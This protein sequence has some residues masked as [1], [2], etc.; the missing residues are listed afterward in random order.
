[1][2]IAPGG[3]PAG[4]VGEGFVPDPSPAGS[5]DTPVTA[6][7]VSAGLFLVV[8]CGLAGAVIKRGRT[9]GWRPAAPGE[10]VP[11]RSDEPV[12]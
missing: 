8:L 1:M 7:V 2:A 10:P 12:R 5:V 11:M 3:A 4:V 9:R 6:I